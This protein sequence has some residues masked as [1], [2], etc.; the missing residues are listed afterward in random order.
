MAGSWGRSSFG[1]SS[2]P[3]L[4]SSVVPKT[5]SGAVKSA[6]PDIVIDRI[7]DIPYEIMASMIFESIG[8]QEILNIARHDLVN[9]QPV[10]Y[11]AI[12]N[13]Q[14]IQNRFNSTN[15]I[16]VSSTPSTIF[17]NFAI[18]F[19]DKLPLPGMNSSGEYVVNL[20]TGPGGDYVYQEE[21]T[22]DIIINVRGMLPDE[23]VEVQ[24]ASAFEEFNDTIY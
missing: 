8:G 18:K 22:A 23:Q 5:S 19:E 11:A 24:T 13:L 10:S 14:F 15:I 9:G 6:T 20:G 2:V 16:P 21:D 3:K 1:V 12:K 7:E 4:P 17:Q